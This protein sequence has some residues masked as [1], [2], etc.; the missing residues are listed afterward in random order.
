[1]LSVNS[2]TFITGVIVAGAVLGAGTAANGAT[3]RP[4]VGKPLQE[5]QSAASSGRCDAAKQKIREP[6]RWRK[7]RR[8]Q[9]PTR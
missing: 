6:R 1:M 8:S 4:Q 5:A 2:R 7:T 9:S 3:V